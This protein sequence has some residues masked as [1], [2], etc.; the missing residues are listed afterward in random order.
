MDL[1]V[2]HMD[3]M[4]DGGEAQESKESSSHQRPSV[5][6]AERRGMG[7]DHLARVNTGPRAMGLFGNGAGDTNRLGRSVVFQE[8]VIQQTIRIGG[9][10]PGND[11]P[12]S[13]GSSSTSSEHGSIPSLSR[14]PSPVPPNRNSSIGPAP[15]PGPRGVSE[16][17]E[18]ETFPHNRQEDGPIVGES[19]N[20]WI[21]SDMSENPIDV[22][23]RH[24]GSDEDENQYQLDIERILRG[25]QRASSSAVGNMQ[26]SND[27]DGHYDSMDQSGQPQ[28]QPRGVSQ[29]RS[30]FIADIDDARIPPPNDVGDET[31]PYNDE[32]TSQYLPNNSDNIEPHVGDADQQAEHEDEDAEY[33]ATIDEIA[34]AIEDRYNREKDSILE[35][36]EF[37]RK[38]RKRPDNREMATLGL[39]DISNR[40]VVST[41]SSAMHIWENL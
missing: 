5:S 25:I 14:T 12:D 2:D 23:G 35:P 6:E 34:A 20:E 30:S 3:H 29:G 37:Y 39:G 16:N 1:P 31:L 27:I 18:D 41:L 13:S 28:L 19:G 11:D 9:G 22:D 24:A 21:D 7:E 38:K 36:P 4:S 10:D 15:T 32:P 17:E 40:Y 8:G 26:H 33:I